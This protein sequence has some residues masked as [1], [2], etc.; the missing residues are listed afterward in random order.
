M[1]KLQ[2]YT[3]CGG[4]TTGPPHPPRRRRLVRL[5]FPLLPFFL[6]LL[7]LLPFL[8]FFVEVLPKLNNELKND[9]YNITG[10]YFYKKIEILKIS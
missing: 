4:G 1:K 9:I 5:D 6:L 7:P 3:A 2:Y 10:Y 8:L